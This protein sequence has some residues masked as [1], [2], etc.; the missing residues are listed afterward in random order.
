MYPPELP[1]RVAKLEELDDFTV[2]KFS[3]FEE[4]DVCTVEELPFRVAELEDLDDCTVAK[5]SA[6]FPFDSAFFS[7][8]APL[9]SSPLDSEHLNGDR[10]RQYG[11]KQSVTDPGLA[12][13]VI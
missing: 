10:Q 1:F 12:Q 4:L 8:L 2:A 11:A 5:F 13:K 3:A 7:F 6:S 9:T